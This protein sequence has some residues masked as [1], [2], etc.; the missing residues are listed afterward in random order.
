MVDRY[1]LAIHD[2]KKAS[3]S[4]YLHLI[5]VQE[6][7]NKKVGHVNGVPPEGHLFE[8]TVLV[9]RGEQL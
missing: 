1:V 3:T 6:C 4:Y 7:V 2:A 9:E 5:T 8:E